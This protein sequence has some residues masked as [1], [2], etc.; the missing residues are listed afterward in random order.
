M[1]IASLIAGAFLLVGASA[2]AVVLTF[3][4][5]PT[6]GGYGNLSGLYQGYNWTTDTTPNLLVVTQAY[7]NT[8]YGNLVTFP[9]P[10]G[11]AVSNNGA[12]TVTLTAA[13][14][15]MFV[16][17]NAYLW[18]WTMAPIGAVTP[19]QG[20][21]NRG[22][23]TDSVSAYTVDVMGWVKGVAVYNAEMMP[24]DFWNVLTGYGGIPTLY[25]LGGLPWTVD[26][27]TFKLDSNISPGNAGTYWLMDNV[28]LSAVPLP[29]SLY[30]LGAG[31][32]GILARRR[33]A[34]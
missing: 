34:H 3:D 16:F 1:V 12:E 22:G 9:D 27:L 15:G 6:P 19:D 21:V 5:I 33:R 20:P 24:V 29:P 8:G 23:V 14:G 28:N 32:I 7:Y 26:T 2:Q 10:G 25:N 17:N 13:G 4:S 11:N 30:L 31:F 18:S